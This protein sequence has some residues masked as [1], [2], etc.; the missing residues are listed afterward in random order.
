MSIYSKVDFYQQQPNL[1]KERRTEL[2][3]SRVIKKYKIT[4]EELL[5]DTR[6]R[7]IVEPRQIALFAMHKKYGYTSQGAGDYFGKDHAT[8]LYASKNI[9]GIMETD[10]EFNRLVNELI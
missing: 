7:H 3:I 10:K 8:V 6:R 9:K 5:S 4:K 1:S 2:L